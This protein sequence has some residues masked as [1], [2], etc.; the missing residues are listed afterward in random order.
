VKVVAQASAKAT[1]CEHADD[2]ECAGNATDPLPTGD[3]TVK[4]APWAPTLT[5]KKPTWCNGADLE[6]ARNFGQ[7]IYFLGGAKVFADIKQSI[8]Q[9]HGYDAR[10]LAYSACF[11]PDKPSRQRWVS[12][13]RQAIVNFDGTTEADNEAML[14]LAIMGEDAGK[15]AFTEACSKWQDKKVKTID[16]IALRGVMIKL[17]ECP[18]DEVQQKR[19]PADLSWADRRPEFTSEILKAYSVKACQNVGPHDEVD[20]KDG[21]WLKRPVN[22]TGYME[23][24]GDARTLNRAKLEKEI[25]SLN[26]GLAERWVVGRAHGWASKLSYRLT[27]GYRA[28]A[29]KDADYQK[30][31][32]TIPEK[33]FKAWAK[34]YQ[35]Y[36][37]AVEAAW[38][39]E[40]KFNQASTRKSEAKKAFSGCAPGLRKSFLAYL[41]STAPKSA[42]DVIKSSTEGIGYSLLS[43]LTACELITDNLVIAQ[44]LYT[45]LAQLSPEINSPREAALLAGANEMAQIRTDREDFG[46]Q[47][48]KPENDARFLKRVFGQMGPEN[49]MMLRGDGTWLANDKVV[50]K[51]NGFDGIVATVQAKG[52]KSLVTFKV[53]SWKTQIWDCKSTGKVDR[54]DFSGSSAQIIYKQ[55]CKPDGFET[56][57]S[58]VPAM[59]VP[60]EYLGGIKPGVRLRVFQGRE[61]PPGWEAVPGLGLEGF[62][63][64]VKAK[65]VHGLGVAF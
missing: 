34:D 62:T 26:L 64:D 50:D 9:A 35:T 12:L 19:A 48:Y 14:K 37:A 6:K 27:E 20:D 7:P 61:V 30:V 1:G 51:Q 15:Q 33:A 39:Y 55:N 24:G 41:K 31:L 8:W 10:N 47:V 4:A 25:T 43:A 52:G 45:L 29:K 56:R 21:A 16:D 44:G 36:K 46:T 53:E 65:P 63:N 40:A 38:D 23:C 58:Q 3:T 17:L 54:I 57:S 22:I 18:L 5:P 13:A 32:F 49:L 42:T 60:S 28:L 2:P 11:A 59:L